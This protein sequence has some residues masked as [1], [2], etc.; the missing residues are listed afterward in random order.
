MAGIETVEVYLDA[1]QMEVPNLMGTLRCQPSVKSIRP[2]PPRYSQMYV[3]ARQS[4]NLAGDEKNPT[5]GETNIG[6][7]PLPAEEGR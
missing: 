1:D 7:A 2:T 4:G 3:S 5:F 6:A